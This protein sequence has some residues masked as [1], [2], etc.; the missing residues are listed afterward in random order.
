LPGQRAIFHWQQ[1]GEF[2]ANLN[3]EGAGNLNATL[4]GA[5]GSPIASTASLAQGQLQASGGNSKQIHVA[6]LPPGWYALE[7]NDGTFPTYF[8]VTVNKPSLPVYLPLVVR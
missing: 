4:I 8:D 5:S 2:L 1:G 7:F 3:I 6:D